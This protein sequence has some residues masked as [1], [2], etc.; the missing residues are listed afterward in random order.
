MKRISLL[1]SFGL[2]V[3][4]SDLAAPREATA[5]L[6]L[7]STMKLSVQDSPL[8]SG[9]TQNVTLGPGTTT[10]DKGELTL[11]QS[12]VI[13][14]PTSEWLV[15]DYQA[16]GTG[17][18]GAN[19]NINW[20]YS[21]L[22]QATT[23]NLTNWFF[24]WTVNG[25][26]FNSITDNGP[27][28]GVEP[29]P[30]NPSLGNVFSYS[31]SFPAGTSWDLFAQVSPYSYN[32]DSGVD[33]STANGFVFAGLIANTSVPEPSSLCLGAV[34]CLIATLGAISRRNCGTRQSARPAV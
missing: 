30:I 25:Q 34:A 16:T 2:L 20:E 12:V 22:A 9:F 28:S 17:L 14:G 29:D 7:G 1:F 5:G 32:G 26:F 4:T 15:L 10:L 11:T 23:S 19:P 31:G 24:N 18:I 27:W 33:V 3:L 21:A 6:L 8:G 13:A